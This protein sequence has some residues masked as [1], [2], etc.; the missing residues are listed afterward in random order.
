MK[1]ILIALFASILNFFLAANLI[2]LVDIILFSDVLATEINL[3]NTDKIKIKNIAKKITVRIEGAGDP[4][5]GVLYKKKES[6]ALKNKEEIGK[7]GREWYL[8]NCRFSNWK[9]R[10]VE[11]VCI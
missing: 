4:G 5:S 11:F 7:K 6:Y 3:K 2:K 9:K 1:S 8:N 10:M